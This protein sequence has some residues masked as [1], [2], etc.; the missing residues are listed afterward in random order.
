MAEFYDNTFSATKC[1]ILKKFLK[2]F[3]LL[4]SQSLY[5]ILYEKGVIF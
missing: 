3:W 1:T 2:A 5:Q 4:N